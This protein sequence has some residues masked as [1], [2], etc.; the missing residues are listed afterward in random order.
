MRIL[1]YDV[2]QDIF[3]CLEI[4]CD[5]FKVVDNLSYFQNF[6]PSSYVITIIFFLN[7]E[8]NLMKFLIFL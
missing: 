1:K 5:F 2:R 3:Y 4:E 8:L 7:L 6:R